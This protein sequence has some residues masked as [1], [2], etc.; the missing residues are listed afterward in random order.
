MVTC[1][2]DNRRR[3]IDPCRWWPSSA[4][5]ARP[6]TAGPLPATRPLLVSRWSA[7]AQSRCARLAVVA[8]LAL[9]AR[10]LSEGR[11]G[12][13]PRY[14]E[15]EHGVGADASCR[16]RSRSAR[17]RGRRHRLKASGGRCRGGPRRRLLSRAARASPGAAAVA[18]RT[19]R[20]RVC[21][22]VRGGRPAIAR[23]CS[24]APRPGDAGI[25]AGA[26]GDLTLPLSGEE[27]GEL[28]RRPF[29][30]AF[31]DRELASELRLAGASRVRVERERVGRESLLRARAH[32]GSCDEDSSDGHAE[33]PDWL[34]T[35]LA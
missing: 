34:E 1:R 25:N 14:E 9:L 13:S 18:S 19:G 5:P 11:G 16:V 32:L 33:A 17:G 2:G 8:E 27:H 29:A 26:P 15:V 30:H 24:A 21:V 10:Q 12:R 3:P 20:H 35:S 31:A 7:G 22:S 28:G 4:A 6:W 23:D